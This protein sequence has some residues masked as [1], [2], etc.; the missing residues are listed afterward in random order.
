MQLSPQDR[1]AVCIPADV[2]KRKN[3][4]INIQCRIDVE[5]S[6]A[7]AGMSFFTLLAQVKHLLQFT[8]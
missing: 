6:P 3:F 5:K 1:N 2:E 7:P 4:L 8:F